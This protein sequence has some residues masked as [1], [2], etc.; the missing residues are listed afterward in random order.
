MNNR[1]PAGPE[2]L[3][4]EA[5]SV[6]YYLISTSLR[7]SEL[8]RRKDRKVVNS[9]PSILDGIVNILKDFTRRGTGSNFFLDKGVQGDVEKARSI[10][11]ARS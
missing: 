2:S 1:S 10:L 4:R 9:T 7:I 11:F 6:G 5:D 8:V 3:S